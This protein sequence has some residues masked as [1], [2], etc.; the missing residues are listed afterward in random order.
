MEKK[1]EMEKLPF[2]KADLIEDLKNKKKWEKLI[3]AK[4][5]NY[6]VKNF[7]FNKSTRRYIFG[8]FL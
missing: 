4:L 3:L 5:I 6:N 8:W 2:K 7:N 1:E